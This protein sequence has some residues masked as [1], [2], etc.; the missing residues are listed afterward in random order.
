MRLIVSMNKE[1]Q[2]A[3]EVLLGKLCGDGPINVDGL[4][5]NAAHLLAKYKLAALTH[6]ETVVEATDKGRKEYGTRVMSAPPR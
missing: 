1:E 4:N 3:A 5:S 6:N 2:S